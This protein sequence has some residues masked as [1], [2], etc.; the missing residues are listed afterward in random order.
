MLVNASDKS[1]QITSNLDTMGDLDINNKNTQDL[2]NTKWKWLVLLL[3]CQY[4]FGAFYSSD[5][6]ATLNT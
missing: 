3:A 5:I 1:S 2:R 6:G 4:S